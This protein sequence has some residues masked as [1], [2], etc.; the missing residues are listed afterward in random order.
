MSLWVFIEAG[1]SIMI[2]LLVCSIVSLAIIGERLW[3][4][5]VNK[6]VPA[7][8]IK[9]VWA[10]VKSGDL[11]KDKIASLKDNSPLGRILAA[12]LINA[13][14]GR[15]IMKESIVDAATHEI[16]N[17]NK[18]LNLLGSIAAIA[19]LMGL[20][21]TVFGMIEVFAQI[22]DSQGLGRSEVLAGGINKALY[23][24][25]FGLTVAIPALFF[26]RFFIRKIDEITVVMEQ[27]ATK[28]VDV[29]HGDRA[30]DEA[31]QFNVKKQ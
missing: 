12:G 21:G 9:Q 6:L 1:G 2:V 18:F 17:M 5:R 13:K 10:W 25:A 24:T 7:G 26:Y 11:S 15:D 31:S 22:V 3:A 16:H 20:L 29:I 23:T 27:D 28:L 4:L 14:Y 30:N 19:P 8:L